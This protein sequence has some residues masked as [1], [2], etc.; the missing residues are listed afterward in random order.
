MIFLQGS[1]ALTLPPAVDQAVAM[2]MNT[3]SWNEMKTA[4]AY[5]IIDKMAASGSSNELSVLV[6]FWMGLHKEKSFGST[7]IEPIE[8]EWEDVGLVTKFDQQFCLR[9]PSV[10]NISNPEDKKILD[11]IPEVQ[12]PQPDI[13]FGLR[14]KLGT[15]EFFTEAERSANM[16]L[17]QTTQITYD[18]FHSFAV[19]E[20]KKSKPIELAQVQALRG[21]ST[22]VWAFRHNQAQA[23]ML[24]LEDPGIDATNIAFSFAANTTLIR[25][26]VHYAEVG[27]D[28]RTKFYMQEIRE[29]SLNKKD[30]LKRLRSD[31]DHILD[32]G[33]LTRINC[34]GGTKEILSKIKKHRSTPQK[35]QKIHPTTTA[36]A[37][38]RASGGS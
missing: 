38:S 31:L 27:E 17:N 33:T 16:I 14:E 18:V 3:N 15:R 26:F 2:V 30:Q 37:S 23:A 32:W 13:T 29:F 9:G 34:P 7:G 11:A 24:N 28:K 8:K 21:G 20:Q 36:G 6:E 4:S 1:E 5:K 22:L 10:L 25:I 35:A 12:H 19:W